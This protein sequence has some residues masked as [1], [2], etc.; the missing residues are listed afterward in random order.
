MIKRLFGLTA[1][2]AL[3]CIMVLPAI[4]LATDQSGSGQPSTEQPSPSGYGRPYGMGPGMMGGYGYGPGY[5]M[6]FGMAGGYGYGSPRGDGYGLPYGRG[7][8]ST[9]GYGCGMGSGMMGPYAADALHLDAKQRE[10]VGTIERDVANKNWQLLGRLR[11]ECERL[12][13]LY[14]KPQLDRSAVNHVY[15][16]MAKLQRQMFEN[17][18]DAQQRLRDVLNREQQ[19]IWRSMHRGMGYGMMPGYGAGP[20]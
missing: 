5:G 13:D 3:A 10:E 4:A 17:R 7:P 12:Y 18:L 2:A 19:A 20:Q 16:E 14:G 15:K 1:P 8:G 11:T 9:D 6:R